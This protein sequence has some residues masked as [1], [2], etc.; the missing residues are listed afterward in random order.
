MAALRARQAPAAFESSSFDNLEKPDLGFVACIEG[1]VLEAQALLLF[2]SIRRYAGRFSDCSLYALSPR[3]GRAISNDA[4]RKLDE[5]G[6]V[7]TDKLLNTECPEYGS[8]NRVAAAAYVEETYA[9]DVLVILDSDTLFLREPSELLLPPDVDAAVRPVDVKGM[10]TGGPSD[11]CDRYWQELCRCCGVNY[12]EIPWRESFVDRQRI[13]ANY[14]GGLVVVRSGLGILRRWADFFF[15]SVRRGLR[16]YTDAGSFRTGAGWVE[17]IAG[18]LWGSNQA[19][20][21]LAI[22]S[23]SRRVLELPPTYNYP[24]HQHKLIDAGLVRKVFPQL[25]HVHYHWLFEPDALP[26]NP[27]FRRRGP[28]SASQK[29]WLRSVTPLT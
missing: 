1:G 15:R 26:S 8:A 25:V 21:S 19:A 3:A 24:L 16:P 20:L 17:P 11:S 7:Y 29:D 23:T 12:E 2:D 22:W 27:L 6:A 18:N 5:L 10:S 9:H 14:N 13:K 28:L 4:R